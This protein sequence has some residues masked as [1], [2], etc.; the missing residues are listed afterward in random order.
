[1]NT[2]SFITSLNTDKVDIFRAII[3][4]FKKLNRVENPHD[5]TAYQALNTVAEAI[6]KV[7]NGKQ[8]KDKP[9]LKLFTTA[10]RKLNLLIRQLR[11]LGHDTK[12]LL[13]PLEQKLFALLPDNI[14]IQLELFEVESF[15]T[16]NKESLFSPSFRRWRRE[17]LYRDM[18]RIRDI[19]CR[20]AY[21]GEQKKLERLRA[22]D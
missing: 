1:M 18:Q 7:W 16:G 22:K 19:I 8:I 11:D 4:D 15:E 17:I 10:I 6:Q 21:Q 12:T 20:K 13:E 5:S 2:T 14:S 3:I 9:A